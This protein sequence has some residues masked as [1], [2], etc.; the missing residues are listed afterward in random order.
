MPK[1]N[2]LFESERSQLH[3]ALLALR[4]PPQAVDFALS[5]AQQVRV[6]KAYARRKDCPLSYSPTSVI[7]VPF[8]K[9][10]KNN[11]YYPDGLPIVQPEPKP[12]TEPVLEP[13]PIVDIEPVIESV[14]KSNDK[15][16]NPKPKGRGKAKKVTPAR[17]QVNFLLDDSDIDLLNELAIEQDLSF[18]QALR[19]A[20]KFY[21]KNKQ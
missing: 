6:Y 12:I 16:A 13:V 14:T 4:L 1:N 21:L 20:V 19:S 7:T 15:P 9:L 17:S 10:D 3:A 2:K 5:S 18:S 11:V 8:S